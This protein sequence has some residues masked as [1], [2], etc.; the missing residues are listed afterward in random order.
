MHSRSCSRAAKILNDLIDAAIGA[1]MHSDI[2]WAQMHAV[3]LNPQLLQVMNRHSDFFRA[4]Q[5]AHY[6]AMFVDFALL[7]DNTRG[8]SSI[9]AY[10]RVVQGNIAESRLAQLRTE[11]ENLQKLAVPLIKVRNVTVAHVNADT[12][13]AEFFKALGITWNE[14]RNAINGA[15][16]FVACIADSNPGQ[17]GIPRDGRLEEATIL[18]FEAVRIGSIA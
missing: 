12:T 15:V 18:L 9:A 1:K 5:D 4:S 7:F 11:F 17:I 16:A 8:V 6:K 14:I 10:L 3:K 2:W 13:E